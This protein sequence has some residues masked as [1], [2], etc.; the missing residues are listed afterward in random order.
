MI[1][2]QISFNKNG[3]R[4]WRKAEEKIA[5]RQLLLRRW[6]ERKFGNAEDAFA[7]GVSTRSNTKIYP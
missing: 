2:R 7:F 6:Q 5:L 3:K 1:K 4:S